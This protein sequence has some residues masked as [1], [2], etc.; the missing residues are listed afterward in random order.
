FPILTQNLWDFPILTP[1]FSRFSPFLSQFFPDFHFLPCPRDWVFFRRSC[2]FFS[3][4]AASWDNSRTF[5]WALGARL[6][7]VD[8][9]EE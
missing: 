3:S 6:L 2:Y 5:C 9:S 7:E 4:F 1:I 8:D